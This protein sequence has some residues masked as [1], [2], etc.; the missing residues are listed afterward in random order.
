MAMRFGP[1]RFSSGSS[2]RDEGSTHDRAVIAR[3][4][5]AY[6]IGAW[7]G[8]VMSHYRTLREEDRAAVL[9]GLER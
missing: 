4:T 6:G 8:D 3:T 7:E 9:A 2:P 1:R 5:K